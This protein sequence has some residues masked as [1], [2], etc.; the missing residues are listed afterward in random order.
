MDKRHVVYPYDGIL[1]SH[2]EELSFDTRCHVEE[3]WKQYSEW[4]KPVAKGH[5]CMIPCIGEGEGLHLSG[6]GGG[7]PGEGA[8]RANTPRPEVPRQEVTVGVSRE[9]GWAGRLKR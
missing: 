4:K 9:W 3:P 8:A 6:R 2:K 5:N 7:F 1:L